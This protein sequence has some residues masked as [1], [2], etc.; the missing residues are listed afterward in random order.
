MR[1][2]GVVPGV[3]RR[4]W[5]A[6]VALYLLGAGVRALAAAPVTAS[7]TEGSAYYV[8]VAANLV[9]GR[10]LV[11]DALWSYATP[12]LEVPR[13]AFELWLPMASF[14]AAVPMVVLG[15]TLTSAQLG[16]AL[17]GALVAPLTWAIA[18]DAALAHGLDA[19]RT[20]AVAAGAGLLAAVLA[21]FLVAVA[22][23][24]S[25]T[26]F[27]V[28]GTLAAWLMPR[29]L[30]AMGTGHVAAALALGAS[31]GLAWLSRQE[32]I[33]L[34]LAYLL[35]LGSVA[36]AA[37][38]GQRLRGALAALAPT[39][40]AG[41]AIVVPWLARQTAAFGTPFAGQLLENA[42]LTRNEQIFAYLER[43]DLAG[44]LAQGVAAIVG[45]V[46]GAVA[47]QLLGVILLPAFPV[48]AVG[49]LAMVALRRS[50]ALRGPT[51]LAALLLAGV[52]TF[53]AT[54]LLFPVATLWGTFLHASGPLMVGLTVAA[55][56]GGDALLARISTIRRWDRPNVVVAPIAL[57]AVAVVLAGL[58]VLTVAR[59]ARTTGDRLTAV[60]DELA[61][62]NDIAD[63]AGAPIAD[64]GPVVTDHPMW[65]AAATRRP[66]LALPDEPVWSLARLARAF[67]ATLVLVFD[68][69][70]RYPGALLARDTASCLR[71][72]PER[73]GPDGSTAWLFRLDPGR[74]AP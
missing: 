41:A 27:L 47:H 73:I 1:S 58:Q 72:A 50:P 40:V 36:G 48:G 74:C 33:W 57:L 24:E 5:V 70:G 63:A 3:L 32:A 35:L 12:P 60:A 51:A 66:T 8:A 56:L 13:A 46:A 28:F 69:R 42:F 20:R 43:P 71:S 29:A 53:L 54:A 39:V 45:N 17:F 25:T 11:T 23:P 37:P 9:E 6:P 44:F 38:G 15:P 4:W 61:R 68:E 7:A 14:V 65:L 67:G 52:L 31:L 21:P 49:L 22:A 10:G 30:G 34:G 64:H 19:R 16:F 62:R 2:V 26:P 59:Q 18:R 55:A